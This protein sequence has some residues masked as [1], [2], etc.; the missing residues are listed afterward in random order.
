MSKNN[1]WTKFNYKRQ[2]NEMCF[3][4]TG[5]WL[6]RH[7][8]SSKSMYFLFSCYFQSVMIAETR[9][10]H[11]INSFTFIV[12]LGEVKMFNVQRVSRYSKYYRGFSPVYILLF[13]G[14]NNFP[15]YF[16]RSVSMIV[17]WVKVIESC[18]ISCIETNNTRGI[19]GYA[20]TRTR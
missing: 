12:F 18:T 7:R 8:F 14:H 17:R 19:A 15:R 5:G 2:T 9:D 4:G 3:R 11:R 20:Y 6:F 10:F 13:T 16:L 1:R